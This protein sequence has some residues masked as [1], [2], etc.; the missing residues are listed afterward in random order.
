MS[1]SPNEN[2]QQAKERRLTER[3][4]ERQER[5]Q[6]EYEARAG[7]KPR[8]IDSPPPRKQSR[9]WWWIGGIGA[10]F[11]LGLAIG[12][13]PDDEPQEVVRQP[14]ATVTATPTPEPT[15]GC[16]AHSYAHGHS[17]RYGVPYGHS[18]CHAYA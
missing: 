17:D 12:S 7:I 8:S 13:A 5:E 4:R 3:E 9:T 15:T 14:T 11:V 1:G 6:R 16:H 18:D 2:R 10:A